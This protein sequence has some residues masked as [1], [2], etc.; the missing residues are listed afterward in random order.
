MIADNTLTKDLSDCLVGISNLIA[1]GTGRALELPDSALKLQ[2]ANRK[3][4][5]AFS[6]GPDS[7]ALLLAAH[8]IAPSFNF[9]VQ[10][11]HINHGLRGQE[12]DAEA[13]FCE[14]ICQHL[15]IKC[16]VIILQLSRQQTNRQNRFSEDSLRQA[17][18]QS[19]Q[20]F[21][22]EEG[23]TFI[24]TAH[25][26]DDQAETILFRLF[27]GTALTG[28][29]GIKICRTLGDNNYLLRP[30]LSVTKELCQ[31]FLQ[32]RSIA[33]CNDSSNWDETY[34]RNYVR[35]S[36]MP[37]I[38]RRF[39]G[40]AQHLDSMRQIIAS[41]DELLAQLGQ[42]LFNRLESADATAWPLELLTQE[43]LALQRRA[44]AHALHKRD[45]A[46]SFARIEE[47]LALTE[48]DNAL[49]LNEHWRV[50]CRQGKLLW[51]KI[52]W[53]ANN[54]EINNFS[55]ATVKMPVERA[56]QWEKHH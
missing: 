5:V 12:S 4:L 33:A 8:T 6:G 35:H 48:S 27:R 22:Q 53:P 9:A 32:N 20:N 25:T 16:K 39:P 15:S 19:L 24:L 56:V 11:C 38:T 29:T 18:Y 52:H 13:T 1:P 51:Q 47:I 37:V 44:V 17:R 50:R 28:L 45:I 30:L 23:I 21:A 42:Q 36:I 54:N 26:L 55:P 46:L 49:N 41:E 2:T 43:P 40:F 34:N 31:Q 14:E 7:T 3:L 10:A